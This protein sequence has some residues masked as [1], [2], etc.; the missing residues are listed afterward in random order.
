MRKIEQEPL[1][2]L[3]QVPLVTQEQAYL[4]IVEDDPQQPE[5]I[6]VAAEGGYYIE[7]TSIQDGGPDQNQI[8]RTFNMKKQ[9]EGGQCK[10]ESR[11]DLDDIQVKLNPPP[12]Q[13]SQLLMGSP[14]PMNIH[15]D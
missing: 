3:D 11:P 13:V 10:Y 14:V 6:Q 1:A 9:I 5:S 2:I 7:D 12:P 8:T 4:A 15:E